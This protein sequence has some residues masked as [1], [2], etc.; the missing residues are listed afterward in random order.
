MRALFRFA[1]RGGAARVRRSPLVE[2]GE[3]AGARAARGVRTRCVGREMSG[4]G[5][6][7]RPNHRVAYDETER[8]LGGVRGESLATAGRRS[9][10]LG[11]PLPRGGQD[12]SWSGAERSPELPSHRPS[13]VSG[14]H[15]DRASARPARLLAPRVGGSAG[16]HASQVMFAASCFFTGHVRVEGGLPSASARVLLQVRAAAAVPRFLTTSPVRQPC[17]PVSLVLGRVVRALRW[18]DAPCDLGPRA[19]MLRSACHL[20]KR[21]ELGSSGG[22]L[23]DLVRCVGGAG[24]VLVLQR[25]EPSGSAALPTLAALGGVEGGSL[26][27]EGEGVPGRTCAG[28]TKLPLTR[29]CVRLLDLLQALGAGRVIN[30]AAGTCGMVRRTRYRWE[31]MCVAW[32]STGR[33]PACSSLR[34]AYALPLRTRGTHQAPP[35]NRAGVRSRR[36]CGLR[37]PSCVRPPRCGATT[38]GAS[39]RT[40]VRLGSRGGVGVHGL[41]RGRLAPGLPPDRPQ[42]LLARGCARREA[43]THL[44][45]IVGVTLRR[46]PQRATIRRRPAVLEARSR[47]CV[48]PPARRAVESSV[49]HGAGRSMAHA[50]QSS[51]RPRRMVA[52]RPLRSAPSLL[53]P[54]G[55][56]VDHGLRDEG[57]AIAGSITLRRPS[58]RPLAF[59]AGCEGEGVSSASAGAAYAGTLLWW[60]CED[61]AADEK[62]TARAWGRRLGAPDPR[63]VVRPPFP[64]SG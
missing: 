60:M 61:P 19:G 37:H 43:R 62:A 38:V 63:W 50:T 13:G 55:G 45:V 27:S 11:S 25:V 16:L 46:V 54:A 9:R 58:G 36:P 23:S 30:L 47:S 17:W 57:V 10:P 48:L 2:G 4:N 56:L 59:P 49:H 64:A 6:P 41:V 51:R 1:V 14:V 32:C 8:V 24:L 12:P 53:G 35:T 40:R 18:H 3:K 15:V 33:P 21:V 31:R 52:C 42:P 5:R 34:I 7:P 28:V 29:A 26:T 39:P 20:P 44:V 22:A